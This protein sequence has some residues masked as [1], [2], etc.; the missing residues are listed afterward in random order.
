M[1]EGAKCLESDPLGIRMLLVYDGLN[2]NTAAARSVRELKDYLTAEDVRV[3][4][5]ESDDDAKAVLITDPTVQ[6]VLL[7]LNNK[8]DKDYAKIIEL[9]KALR[10]HN[11][12]LPVF[13][14][15]GR[16][17]ASKVP[18]EIL[19]SVN[20]FIWVMEDTPDFIAGRV[21]AATERYRQFIL[22]PMF[23]ALAAFPKCTNIPGIRRGI[24]AA[25]VL[26]IRLPAVRFSTFSANRFFVRICRFRSAN[27]DRCLTIPVRSA[28]AKNTRRGFSAPTAPIT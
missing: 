27:W 14:L 25:P 12:E 9:L 6:C 7:K 24:P 19:E 18:S 2:D 11:R 5:S 3:I 8:D 16:T 15:A 28:K 20:D 4:V 1:K 10:D 22:P 17:A 21:L 13:L 23:K 26:C